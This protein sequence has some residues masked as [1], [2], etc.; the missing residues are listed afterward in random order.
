M[1]EEE[2]KEGANPVGSVED[3][4]ESNGGKGIVIT[5]NKGG[6]QTEEN[7]GVGNKEVEDGGVVNGCG[8]IIGEQVIENGQD[9][10]GLAELEL[11]DKQEAGEEVAGREE[12]TPTEEA[13]EVDKLEEDKVEDKEVRES[14]LDGEGVEDV[15]ESAGEEVV[16]EEEEH[17][18]SISSDGCREH[19]ASTGSNGRQN[20]PTRF[21]SEHKISEDSVD[22]LLSDHA[23]FLHIRVSPRSLAAYTY[24]PLNRPVGVDIPSK[25]PFI[26]RQSSVHQVKTTFCFAIAK[27]R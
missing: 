1:E 10:A 14:G 22:S 25:F 4:V 2:D 17:L 3:S 8:T 27:K 26:S 20:Y 21:R 11:V 18:L 23:Y 9:E 7:N 6:G 16:V 5:C 19:T 24:E 13:M 12:E 15:A